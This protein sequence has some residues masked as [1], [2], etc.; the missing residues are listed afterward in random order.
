MTNFVSSILPSSKD[1]LSNLGFIGDYCIFII[2][3]LD[4]Y[5]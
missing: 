3:C 5:V 1:E 2:I 4:D